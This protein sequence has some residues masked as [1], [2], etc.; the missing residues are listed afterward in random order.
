MRPARV[1]GAGL[2]GL[3]AA[4]HLTE[5]GFDVTLLEQ[6]PRPGGLID[7]LPTPHGPVETAANAF[8]WDDT[9][10]QWFERLQL[11]AVRPRAASKRRYIFRDGR[12]R[13]WPLGAVES[14]GVAVRL[15]AAVMT[16]STPALNGESMKAW[17][18]RVIGAAATRWLLE[19]AMQGIYA[20]APAALSAEA[21]F[22]GRRRGPRTLVAPQGG[23]GQFITRLREQLSD[24]GA[25]F[26]FNTAVDAID[27]SVPTVIATPADVAARLLAPHAPRLAALVG[28]IRI[29]P[30]NTV[31]MFFA[32]HPD[33]LRGFGVLFPR[34]TGIHALGVLFN[35]EIFDGRGTTRSETWIT[36]D[37]DPGL[38]PCDDAR[39]IETL[40][41]DRR[42]M[43]GRDDAPLST[44]VTCWARAI[45]V[46]DKAILAVSREIDTLP[47]WLAVAGNY[48]GR[49]GVAALLEIAAA[50]ARRLQ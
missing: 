2:S 20:S 26:E 40:A 29:A 50:A 6:A 23:M 24:R 14:A 28:K 45:P 49:I 27:D 30:L 39:L 11:T 36:G 37:R 18:D 17:G 10:A 9:V 35:T 47:P 46:Y 41:A 34:G 12:A 33:D 48:L 42:L 3:A 22:G 44:H 38:A 16:R 13:R 25:R 19:P 1:I 4:W 43:T 31:T 15:G 5:R 32:P 21:I 7:T 8:V